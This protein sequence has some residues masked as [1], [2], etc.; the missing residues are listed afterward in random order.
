M[1]RDRVFF[2]VAQDSWTS[3]LQL[4]INRVDEHGLGHGY[5]IA[6]PKLNG[7]S[8]VVLHHDL[9]QHGADKI[10]NHLDTVFPSGADADLAEARDLVRL[11]LSLFNPL[12]YDPEDL[13]PSLTAERL[14]QWADGDSATWQRDTEHGAP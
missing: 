14:P 9:D 12:P 7:P 4:S 2:E 13:D 1:A 5:R 3:G 8:T 11:L 6:G 10:R